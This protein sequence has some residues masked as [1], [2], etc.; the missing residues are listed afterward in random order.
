M[1]VGVLTDG[2]TVFSYAALAASGVLTGDVEEVLSKFFNKGKVVWETVDLE[3]GLKKAGLKSLHPPEVRSPG[4]FC[5]M[6]DICL[7]F[8]RQ[9]LP[10]GCL[11]F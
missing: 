8:Q 1:P 2:L 4:A 9:S 5:R 11:E 10:W 7:S 3:E 6:C